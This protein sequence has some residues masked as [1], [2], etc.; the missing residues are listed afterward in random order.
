MTIS[1]AGLDMADHAGA[2]AERGRLAGKAPTG[3]IQ[4]LLGFHSCVSC[5]V[6][7][8]GGSNGR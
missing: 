3:L 1:I 2:K 8:T 4:F 6:F 5:L 7:R